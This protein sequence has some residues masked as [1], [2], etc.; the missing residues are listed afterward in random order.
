MQGG[1]EV[2]DGTGLRLPSSPGSSGPVLDLGVLLGALAS[3]IQ[4]VTPSADD[5]S[6]VAPAVSWHAGDL[7]ALT[8]DAVRQRATHSLLLSL[9]PDGVDAEA[10]CS[11]LAGGSSDEVVE[12][13]APGYITKRLSEFAKRS[14]ERLQVDARKLERQRRKIRDAE[15]EIARIEAGQARENAHARALVLTA[16]VRRLEGVLRPV[17]AMGPASAL[18]VGIADRVD[19]RKIMDD[20]AA[21]GHDREFTRAAGFAIAETAAKFRA[22]LEAGE[23]A[24]PSGL[25]VADNAQARLVVEQRAREMLLDLVGEAGASDGAGEVPEFARA[26]LG[27]LGA[28]RVVVRGLA[29]PPAGE[30]EMHSAAGRLVSEGSLIPPDAGSPAVD[31]TSGEPGPD[32]FMH[33]LAGHLKRPRKLMLDRLVMAPVNEPVSHPLD[34]PAHD[35]GEAYPES[36]EAGEPGY[37]GTTDEFDDEREFDPDDPEAGMLPGVFP[38]PIDYSSLPPFDPAPSEDD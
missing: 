31:G 33:P 12:L 25:T 35:V 17:M 24:G 38:P 7:A 34:E 19:A 11:W 8:S 15:A 32:V 28:E 1:G 13:D 14:V 21:V 22:R 18:L 29:E 16:L 27:K 2:F 26:L 5:G 30:P 36:G 9:I 4:Q 23:L 20:V 3:A 10:W 6:P 37:P